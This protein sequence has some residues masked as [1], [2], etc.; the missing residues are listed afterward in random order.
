[1]IADPSAG[2]LRTNHLRRH[3]KCIPELVDIDIGT[4][5]Y[6]EK[7]CSISFTNLYHYKL[8]PETRRVGDKTAGSHSFN[9]DLILQ[10]SYHFSETEFHDFFRT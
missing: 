2:L 5:N 10:G 3:L 6:K 9:A 4:L 7:R 1:M 8:S